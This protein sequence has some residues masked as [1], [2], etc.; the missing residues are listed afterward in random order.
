MQLWWGY[1][2]IIKGYVRFYEMTY[3]DLSGHLYNAVI[4]KRNLFITKIFFLTE[5]TVP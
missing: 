4:G 5:I 3:K 2:P 1:K